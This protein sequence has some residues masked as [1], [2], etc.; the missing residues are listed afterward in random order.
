VSGNYATS[1]HLPAQMVPGGRDS[2]TG[3]GAAGGQPGTPDGWLVN[4][5]VMV[6]PA[7]GTV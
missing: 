4:R 7:V 6:L 5:A 3:E 1:S 2:C